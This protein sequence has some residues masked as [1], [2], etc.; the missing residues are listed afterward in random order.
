MFR[1]MSRW[2][3]FLYKLGVHPWEEDA[4][5]QLAQL[6][7]LLERIERGHDGPHGAALDL[8]SGTG[9]YSIELAERGWDVVGVDVVP[10]AVELA[11]ERARAA[12]VTA[13]FCEGDVTDLEGVGV[14]EGYRLFLDAECFNH[15]NDDQRMAVGRGV[16]A[17]AG[18]D[19]EM[20]VLVWRR[21]YRGPLPR[22]AS[23]D[24]LVRSFPG[25]TIVEEFEYGAPLPF[26]LKRI[27]PRWYLL[28]RV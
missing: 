3:R 25:W 13:R 23:R 10:E 27:E 24:D 1:G 20:L 14:G 19:A 15:L 11:R 22:G 21:A 8:G 2:Y 26:P 5:S 12:N 4:E 7:S 16:N 28:T 18:S 9:R 17:V 6:R